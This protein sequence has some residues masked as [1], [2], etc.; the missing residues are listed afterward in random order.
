[1][2]LE[3]QW[4][5]PEA[6]QGEAIVRPTR[7]GISDLDA[8]SARG[9]A[10]GPVEPLTLGHEFVGV[11]E[12]LWEGADRE[13]RK[14]WEGKRVV[15]SADIACA[16]CDLCRA[17][18]GQHCR[19]RRVLGVRGWD[20]CLAER[21]KLPLRNLAEVPREVHDD[22]AVFTHPV[23]Q[24]AHVAQLLRVEGK[25][26]VTVLGDGVAALLCAQVLVRLNASVRVLGDD[27][28]KFTLCEKWGIKHRHA[29]E[30]GR[31]ADQD[32]VVDATGN[33]LELAAQLVRPRGKIVLA[34]SA[35]GSVAGR[36]A[37][38]LI[39]E[40]ELEVLGS[41]GGNPAEAVGMLAR[42]EIDTLP[43]I[44]RRGRLADGVGLLDAAGRPEQ[45]RI[46]V[47]P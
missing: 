14:R 25:P 10:A 43:L 24:A 33:G 47:D 38:A 29:G 2:V 13:T 16:R 37:L 32:I 19:A 3:S 5:V 21:F 42:G 39:V 22:R 20:G 31:R 30:A 9:S 41:R 17:G 23:A 11:V 40:H 34:A 1:V 46:L 26:Y 45:L 15:G 27:A 8:R 12:R 36:A 18:L 28:G 7:M 35:E 6:G 4:P 44:T